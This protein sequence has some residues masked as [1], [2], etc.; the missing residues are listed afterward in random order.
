MRVHQLNCQAT[1]TKN[2]ETRDNI[3]AALTFAA[4]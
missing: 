3:A 1:A 4:R 2:K